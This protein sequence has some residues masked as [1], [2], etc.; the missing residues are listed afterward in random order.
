MKN[1]KFIQIILTLVFTAAGLWSSVAF[2]CS[3]G[4][5]A[6]VLWNGNW[7]PAHVLKGKGSQCLIHYDGYGS[8]WDEWVGP[9]RIKL[10]Y[11]PAAFGKGDPVR[12]LWKGN[13]WPAHVI[14]VK[15]SQIKIHYDGYDSSWDEWVGPD[16]YRRP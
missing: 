10:A 15:G 9:E 7:Y 8:N 14:G 5:S 2:A 13:W 3:S 4:D 1:Q 6:Q 11:A 16:R 12:I